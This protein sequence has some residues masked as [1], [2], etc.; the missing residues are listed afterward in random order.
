MSGAATYPLG[1]RIRPSGRRATYLP[2]NTYFV[3]AK[4]RARVSEPRQLPAFGVR[5]HMSAEL[6]LFSRR[7]KWR[8]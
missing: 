4:L 7:V 1:R 3:T 5:E 2:L 8:K 6:F